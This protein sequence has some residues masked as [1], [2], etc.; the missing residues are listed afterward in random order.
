MLDALGSQRLLEDAR[1]QLTLVPSNKSRTI[2][3]AQHGSTAAR[4]HGSTAARIRTTVACFDQIV[5]KSN[6]DR[7]NPIVVI[8]VQVRV[9]VKVQANKLAARR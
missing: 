9:A 5:Q 1:R 6:L 4:Q 8:K 7:A 3:R 2:A